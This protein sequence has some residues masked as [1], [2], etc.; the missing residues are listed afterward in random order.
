MHVDQVV[1]SDFHLSGII[2]MSLGGHV[3][4]K[5]WCWL[6]PETKDD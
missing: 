6:V 5:I 3:K 4:S 2:L 1:D